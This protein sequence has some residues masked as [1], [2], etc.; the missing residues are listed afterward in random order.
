MT[1]TARAIKHN[2]SAFLAELHQAAA[3]RRMHDDHIGVMQINAA[4][5]QIE[6]GQEVVETQ[7]TLAIA[8]R[9]IHAC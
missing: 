3:A 9:F 8:R 1:L 4:I 5:T 2:R 7:Q 6:T